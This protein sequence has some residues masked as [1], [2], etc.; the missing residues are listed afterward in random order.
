MK[1]GRIRRYLVVMKT[2]PIYYQRLTFHGRWSAKNPGQDLYS[3]NSMI[4]Y[5]KLLAAK[6]NEASVVSSENVCACD[7]SRRLYKRIVILLN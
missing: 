6:T 7:T 5:P 1:Q 2:P 3:T 4:S